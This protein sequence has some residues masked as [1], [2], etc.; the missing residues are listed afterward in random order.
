MFNN[1]NKIDA[2][3]Q[4]NIDMTEGQDEGTVAIYW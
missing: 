3:T 2:V 4:D 1:S